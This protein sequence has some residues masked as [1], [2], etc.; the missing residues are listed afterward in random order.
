M[1]NYSNGKVYKIWSV[2]GDKIYIGSTTKEYLSQRM[3]NHRRCYKLNKNGK[4]NN[5]T[6]F[7]LFDEYGI[8]N[9]KIE[10]LETINCNSK[11]ELLK[12]EAKYIRDMDCVNKVIPGRTNKQYQQDNKENITIQR[13]NYRENN[14]EKLKE[15]DKIKYQKFKDKIKERKSEIINCECGCNITK[16]NIAAHRKTDK[17]LRKTEK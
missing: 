4:G 16:G 14:K 1:V 7:I 13:K 15:A 5:I 12:L 17:H 2:L 3:D 11:D 8:S 6:S 9:C 10:L